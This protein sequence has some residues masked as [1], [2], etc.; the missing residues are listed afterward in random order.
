MLRID[1][2]YPAPPFHGSPQMT[3]VLHREGHAVNRKRVQRLRRLMGL[4]SLAPHPDPAAH[5]PSI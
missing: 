3:A 1:E 5:I 2:P 4:Q